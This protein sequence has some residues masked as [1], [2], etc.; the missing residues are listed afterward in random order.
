[1]A[2]AS[3]IKISMSIGEGGQK[4]ILSKYIVKTEYK[5]KHQFNILHPKKT[6]QTEEAKV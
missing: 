3:Q 5:I 1:M 2:Q 6:K 4:V